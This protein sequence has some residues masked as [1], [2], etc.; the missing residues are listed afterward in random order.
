[1][2]NIYI[3]PGW[4]E[5][6]KYKIYQTLAMLAKKKGYDVLFYDVDWNKPLSKQIFSVQENSVIIGFSLGAVLAHLIAQKY[7]CR[8]L[9]LAS[10]TPPHS[11][12]DMKLKNELINLLGQSFIEDISKK[13]HS[14]H[15]ALNQVIIYGDRE[16]EQGD[17]IVPHTGHRL[18][19]RY[20]KEIINLL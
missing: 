1:M 3:I 6:S 9:I 5:S 13:L 12:K 15:Y 19:R 14:K 20:N 17:V 16:G 11:F 4:Q 8:K 10:M 18:N 7:K 2:K